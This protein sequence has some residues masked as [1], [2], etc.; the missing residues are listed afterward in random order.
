MGFSKEE[1]NAIWLFTAST[2]LLGNIDF[3]AGNK[4]DSKRSMFFN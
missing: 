4:N 3:N 1:Q 2:L